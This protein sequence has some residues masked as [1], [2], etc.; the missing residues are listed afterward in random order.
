MQ[1]FYKARGIVLHTIKY[2]ESSLVAY[3]LTDLYGRMNYMVQGVRSSRGRGNKAALLQPMF[4]VE[5]EAGISSHAQMHRI[6]EIRNLVPLSSLPFDVRKSTMALFMAEVLF[7]FIS[8]S[9]V[10]LDRM[11]KGVA[12]F[13][14]WFLVQLSAYLGFYPGNEFSEGAFFDMRSGL[15]TPS[16][17]VHAVCMD[18]DSSS[19]LG[20][21][22]DCSVDDLDSLRLSRERRSAFLESILEF[23]GY[24]LDAIRTVRSISILREVF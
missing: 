9:V 21:L 8:N 15:F 3:L 23:F 10:Q 7:D 20:R 13:H 16:L 12:N 4:L 22:M 24:H 11:E 18:Q 19:L 5:L 14:L 17:P 1:N 2:G 6:R